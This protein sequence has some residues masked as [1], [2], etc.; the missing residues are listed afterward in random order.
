MTDLAA[1]ILALCTA[2]GAWLAVPVPVGWPLGA[3]VVAVAFLTRSAVLLCAGAALLASG[4]AATAWIG[5][6]PPRAGT[7]VS[8]AVTL[9][10]DPDDRGGATRAIAKLGRRH[11]EIS[12]RGANGA[13]LSDRL[14]G[15]RLHVTGRLGPVAEVV[16]SQLAVRHV[17]AELTVT[18]LEPAGPGNLASQWANRLRRTLVR[19]ARALPTGQRALFTGFV[20]GDDRGQSA[21]VVDDFRGSGLSHLLVVSGENVAFVLAVA[22]PL[23]RRFGLRWRLLAGITVL[24]GFGL[25]TRWEPSVLRA[26]AM[27][28]IALAAT[29]LGRPVSALRVLAL[30]VSGLLVADPLLVHSVSFLLS[31]GASAGITLLAAPLARRLPG[32]RPLA[33]GAAVTLAAQAGVA[34]VLVPVFGPLPVAALPANLLA[35]PAAG[36]VMTWGLVAGIPAGLLGGSA[37]ALLHL[38]TRLFVGWIALVA[39]W[40]AAAPLGSLG[41]EPLLLIAGL[42][43]VAWLIARRTV[44][45]VLVAVGLLVAATPMATAAIRAGPVREGAAVVP[46][47]LLW[48]AGAAAVLTIQN[49]SSGRLLSGL[50]AAGVRRLS[51]LV[52][53][54]S[55]PAPAATVAT[56][57]SRIPAELVLAPSERDI[58][59]ATVPIAGTR[60]EAAPFVITVDQAG[61]G[62]AVT[63]ARAP[64]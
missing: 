5:L 46:G 18:A 34:P 39:R 52:V 49:P 40:A 12:A 64:P 21:A 33:T 1:V 6:R 30:A 8:A 58:A 45:R 47:A 41:P 60:V 20:L 25:L 37:A 27:A 11:V 2:A 22:G 51:V 50:H 43:V 36:P 19:G 56:L 62:L 17:G 55:G 16:K 44:S 24:A 57:V 26:E 10:S 31:V 14:A 7:P 3:V 13:V 23:L 59:G 32:P 9:L 54:R 15:E 29:T 48:R 63:V 42:V 28:G 53:E 61:A 35:M 4:L 38:P